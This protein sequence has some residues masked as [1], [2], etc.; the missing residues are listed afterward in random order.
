MKTKTKRRAA[1][2]KQHPAAAKRRAAAPENRTGDAAPRRR[3]KTFDVDQQLLDDARR[4]LGCETETETVR[5]ALE[6]VVARDQQ[7]E[8]IRWLAGRKLFD[9]SK[10]ED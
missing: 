8:A 6:S 4:A 7:I 1:K 9:R 2:A 3:R 5:R 10:I